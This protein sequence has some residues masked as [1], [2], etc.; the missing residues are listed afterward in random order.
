M[1]GHVVAGRPG[2]CGAHRARRGAQFGSDRTVGAHGAS[3]NGADRL[4][5]LDSERRQCGGWLAA[6]GGGFHFFKKLDNLQLQAGLALKMTRVEN[7]LPDNGFY[8]TTSPT[9]V[10]NPC[11]ILILDQFPTGFMSVNLAFQLSD[12]T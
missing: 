9:T 10:P 6:A 2:H 4:V 3:G 8:S 7:V 12:K 1:S 11:Q 5:D